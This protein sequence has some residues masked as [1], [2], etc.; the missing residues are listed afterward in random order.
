MARSPVEPAPALP[1]NRSSGPSSVETNATSSAAWSATGAAK[2]RGMKVPEERRIS[3]KRAL[4]VDAF[5]RAFTIT[6][7]SLWVSALAAVGAATVI[8][9]GAAARTRAVCPEKVTTFPS[10]LGSNPRPWTTTRLPA[11]PLPGDT[12]S[13]RGSRP[14]STCPG[15]AESGPTCTITEALCP[16]D[17]GRA[18]MTTRSWSS[19]ASFTSAIIPPTATERG[20]PFR[21]WPLMTSSSPGTAT[22]GSTDVTFGGR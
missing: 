13:T 10:G 7:V 4:L 12:P 11:D 18:G 22:S 20:L 2:K 17:E 14:R 1:A 21:F 6:S 9:F 19:W 5:P 15:F 16:S 3:T 8:S